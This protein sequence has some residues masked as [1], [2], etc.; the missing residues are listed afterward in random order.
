MS[1]SHSTRIF[2]IICI[3]AQTK[4]LK[5]PVLLWLWHVLCRVT[6]FSIRLHGAQDILVPKLHE[7]YRYFTVS[8]STRNSWR[9]NQ[10]LLNSASTTTSSFILPPP[11]LYFRCPE[12]PGYQNHKHPL[13]F[14]QHW[15]N[16]SRQSFYI[17][18]RLPLTTSMPTSPPPRQT[19]LSSHNAAPSIHSC[20]TPFPQ[21]INAPT[22]CPYSHLHR[23]QFTLH[24]TPYCVPLCPSIFPLL[25]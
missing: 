7:F 19:P 9:M 20:H 8:Q 23:H 21:S 4:K 10:Y 1:P 13:A 5:L 16:V 3:I 17:L 25:P 24:P 11:F 6:E 18:S 22:L 14:W 2:C 15:S 12:V